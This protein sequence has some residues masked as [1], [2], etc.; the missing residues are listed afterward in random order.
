M[1]DDGFGMVYHYERQS[2]FDLQE[3]KTNGTSKFWRSHNQWG[4]RHHFR[5]KGGEA[6]WGG[7]AE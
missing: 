4:G 6:A 5:A 7:D 1:T 2:K 3:F